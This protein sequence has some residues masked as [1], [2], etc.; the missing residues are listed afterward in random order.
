M[1]KKRRSHLTVAALSVVALLATACG[2]DTGGG[3]PGAGGGVEGPTITVG[4]VDFAENRILGQIYGQALEH[5]GYDVEIT[6]NIGNRELVAPQLED[7]NLD[8]IVEYTGN[9]LRFERGGEDVEIRDEQEVYDALNEAYADKGLTALRM[10]EAQDVDAV[11]VT[12]ETAE[13]HGL[14]RISDIA[15]F[16]GTFR[17]GGGPECETRLSCFKGLEEVYGLDNVE[18]VPLDVAGPITVEA[19]KSGEVDGANLFTTQ[20]AIVANDFVVLEDD[21]QLQLPQNIV[22]VIRQEI[23]DA[24]GDDLVSLINEITTSLTTESLTELNAKV[25]IDQEDPDAVAEQWLRE[26]GFLEE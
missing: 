26:N 16:E 10:S 24:Y 11:V 12:K 15:G 18:F 13:E 22:P 4:T 14:E 5:A 17:F 19:L 3:D 1:R 6:E 8:L 21:Q 23:V 2:G 9:A 7:G 25:E 20:S